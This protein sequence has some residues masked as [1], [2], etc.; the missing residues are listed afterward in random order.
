MLTPSQ[1]LS[2]LPGCAREELHKKLGCPQ[3]GQLTWTGQRNTPYHRTSY[4]AYN[5]GGAGCEVPITAQGWAGPW[6][7]GGEQPHCASLVFSWGLLLFFLFINTTT[8]IIIILFYFNYS[9]V[10]ISA[11]G[12]YLFPTLLP[13]P[14]GAGKGKKWVSSWCGTSF[15]A[16][17]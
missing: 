9:P 10:L 17:V 4:S 7:A 6:S 13:I 11:L 3:P 2:S 16:E 5:L 12:F 8:I 15:L 14:V 1:G